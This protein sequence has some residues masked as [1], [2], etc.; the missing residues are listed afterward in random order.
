M[1]KVTQLLKS[2]ILML[3]LMV[4]INILGTPKF[5][6]EKILKSSPTPPFDDCEGEGQGI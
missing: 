1:L 2:S 3:I 4:G 5:F 6:K